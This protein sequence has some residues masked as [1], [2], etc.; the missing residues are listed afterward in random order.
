LPYNPW[1]SRKQEARR[2]VEAQ[3]DFSAQI[4]RLRREVLWTKL[5]SVLLVLLLS[6]FV[7]SERNKHHPQTV[8]ATEFLLKDDAGNVIARL[9]KQGSDGT[10]LALTPRHSV[11]DAELCSFEGDISR[12]SYLV[13]R[14]DDVSRVSLSAGF[15]SANGK[16][17]VQP[18]L[19]IVR[20]NS[21]GRFLNLTLEADARLVIGHEASFVQSGNTTTGYGEYGETAAVSIPEGK[22][23]IDLF[24]HRAKKVWTTQK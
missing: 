9:G 14:D 4:K 8:E 17:P 11:A 13:L 19:Y 24:D 16:L 20:G 22:A 21:G 2:T 6:V 10:C 1:V 5:V 3:I 12:S 7:L 18:G 15:N 23:E